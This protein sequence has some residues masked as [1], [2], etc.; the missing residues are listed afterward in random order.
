MDSGPHRPGSGPLPD[1][2]R[3]KN[4]N[5][6][7]K[8]KLRMH[9]TSQVDALLERQNRAVPESGCFQAR[10]TLQSRCATHSEWW[11]DSI[12]LTPVCEII[13]IIAE[14]QNAGGKVGLCRL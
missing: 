2:P 14:W 8:T 6:E 1:N 5:E 7:S 10:D 13:E 3:W 9:R 4:R 11:S 12:E